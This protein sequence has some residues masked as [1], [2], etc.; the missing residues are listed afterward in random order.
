MF[1][2]SMSIKVPKNNGEKVIIITKKLE[3]INK[4]LKIVRDEDYVYIPILQYPTKKESEEIEKAVPNYCLSTHTFTERKS[5][6]R[7]FVELLDDKLSSKLLSNLPRSIDFVGDIAII[8][9]PSE[10]SAYDKIIGDAILKLYKN[11]RTVLAKAGTVSGVYRLREYK[12]I[13]GE[14]ATE[15]VHKEYGCHY[16]VDLTRAYFSPRLSYEHNRVASLVEEGETIVDLFSGIGPFAILI[17]KTCEKVEVYTIDSNSDAVRFLKENIML[18]KVLGQVHPILGDAR[19]VVDKKLTGVANRVIMNLPGKAIFFMDV[20]C[21]AIKPTGG[22]IHF[23][24]FINSSK[25]LR[26]IKTN[27][28]YEIEKYGRKIVQILNARLVRSTAPHEWQA[29]LDV[30]IC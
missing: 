29:V 2:E 18:N 4:E 28:E 27:F 7:T 25:K 21:K 26:D 6:T 23:Y 15:T 8:E 13:A 1:Q 10:L 20:A 16:R 19:K 24:S 17:A 12:V 30:E 9:I 11:V 5:A 22:V 14:R 3:L